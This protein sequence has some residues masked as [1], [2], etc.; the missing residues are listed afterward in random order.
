[1]PLMRSWVESANDPVG[2]FPLNNLPFGVFDDG[3]GARAG[4]AIGDQVL[5]LGAME[6]LS[7]VA[8]AGFREDALNAFMAA[9]P[10]VWARV[11][12]TLTGL[13]AE[14]SPARVQ[15]EDLLIPAATGC[16]LGAI[17][18]G[19]GAAFGKVHDG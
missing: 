2:A 12:N 4:V 15:V 16:L 11:R 14:G 8:E 13:L 1:M 19:I 17:A 6:G 10:G 9:G 5:D 7:M 3:R 18:G